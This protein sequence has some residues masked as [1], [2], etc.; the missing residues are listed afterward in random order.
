VIMKES[1][2]SDLASPGICCRAESSVVVGNFH[3]DGIS[4]L[5][6]SAIFSRIRP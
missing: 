3:S 4:I 2:A 6:T 5:A 1:L